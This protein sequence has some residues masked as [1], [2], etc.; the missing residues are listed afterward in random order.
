MEEISITAE[1]IRQYF[2]CPR[3]IYWRY[4]RGIGKPRIPQVS[5]GI[6]IHKK[7]WYGR[8]TI[9]RKNY[10]IERQVYLHSERLNL[11]G[12]IDIVIYAMNNDNIEEIIPVEVKTSAIPS[13]KSRKPDVMQLVA[14][15]VLAREKWNKTERGFLYYSDIDKK[16]EIHL[17]EDLSK[18]LESAIEDIKRIIREEIFPEPTR[19]KRRCYSCEAKNFC[20]PE[21]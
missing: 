7:I 13:K 18:Q 21:L 11:S 3:K 2:Y 15:L 17:T 12:T 20:R 19:D 14:Y 6:R 4:V 10:R 5:R 16:F 1:M 9:A 8:K